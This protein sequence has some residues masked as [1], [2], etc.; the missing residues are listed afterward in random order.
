MKDRKNLKEFYMQQKI[1]DNANEPVKEI[2]QT[3][4]NKKEIYRK[5][6]FSSTQNVL[7]DLKE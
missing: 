6:Y 1:Q 5:Q 4:I 7:K 3:F 2:L